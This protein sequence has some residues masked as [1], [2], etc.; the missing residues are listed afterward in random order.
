MPAHPDDQRGL[1]GVDEQQ[2]GVLA[3]P[4]QRED[5]RFEAGLLGAVQAV[6]G[7][8][9]LGAYDDLGAALEDVVAHQP[10]V[11]DD[12]VR[13]QPGGEQ[14]VGPLVDPDEHRLGGA[15]PRAQVAQVALGALAAGHD[16]HGAALDRLSRRWAHRCRRAAGRAPAAGARWWRARR[17]AAGRRARPRAASIASATDATVS[18][19]PRQ[20]RSLAPVE[21]VA[22][23]AQ[24]G[25]RRP[26][27]RMTSGP[28]RSSTGMPAWTSSCG[29]R[30]G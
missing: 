28:T 5:R 25:R 3:G 26:A 9:P 6:G 16:D 1:V 2:R 10:R 15:Q 27:I 8:V 4:G 11:A 19:S 20:T 24:R 23:E 21:R 14:R 7:P 22:V 18:S 30:L 17:P 12:Q 13:A 29:P